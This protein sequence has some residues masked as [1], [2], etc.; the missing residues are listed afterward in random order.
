MG[1]TNHAIYVFDNH[2]QL[3]AAIHMLHRSGFDIKKL[4]VIGKGHHTDDHHVGFLGTGDKINTWSGMGAFWVGVWGVLL[5]PALFFLPTV[6][7][8]A[9]AGPL[10][11]ALLGALEGVVLVGGLSAL[12]AALSQLGVS[13]DQVTNYEAA[14]QVDKYVLMV[15]GDDADALKARSTLEH[16]KVW[17]AA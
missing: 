3:D 12:G 1:K 16:A 5:A 4:S 2:N 10:V 15:H 8:V 7:L 17:E 9:I 11:V 6:G 13:K 14:I